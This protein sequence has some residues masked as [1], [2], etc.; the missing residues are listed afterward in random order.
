MVTMVLVMTLI[1]TRR[2]VMRDLLSMTV[3]PAVL[4]VAVP[5][6]LQA[7]EDTVLASAPVLVLLV[8]GVNQEMIHLI[9]ASLV[10]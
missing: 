4:I 7:V 9:D 6:V 5:P 2:S 10:V 1:T 3:A 8:R